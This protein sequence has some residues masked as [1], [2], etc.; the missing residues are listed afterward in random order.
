[1]A[2]LFTSEAQSLKR[3][4]T[5]RGPGPRCRVCA[6]PARPFA[7]TTLLAKYDV[8]Y[9]KCPACGLVQT[10][11]PYWLAQAYASPIAPSD[12][13]FV[14]RNVR[15]AP[16]VGA[17]ARTCFDWRQKHLDYGGGYG[18]LVRLLRDQGLD[19]YL[20]D[21]YCPNTFAKGFS[22]D[23]DGS[24]QYE[25]TTAFEVFEHL[26]DPMAVA[27][28]ILR[29]SI[30]LLFTTQPL[31]PSSPRPGTGEWSYYSE[32][33]GQH[34]TLYT[35][36]SIRMMA[37]RLGVHLHSRGTDLHLLTRRRLKP[38]LFRNVVRYSSAVVIAQLGQRAR[39]VVDDP[40]LR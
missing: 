30:G 17:L 11:E 1:M 23:L 39:Q 3:A 34:I 10:E 4:H 21:K 22:V 25:L 40:R 37:D 27:D 31:P 7:R 15:N 6:T 9:D 33:E 12:V 14:Q 20:Y 24:Q 8:Q 28:Q 35:L 36:R 29:Q 5:G 19:F 18:L 13:G 38:A 26:P 32:S 2:V 16:I